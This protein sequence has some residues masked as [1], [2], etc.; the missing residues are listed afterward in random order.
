MTFD[1]CKPSVRAC[2]RWVLIVGGRY[3]APSSA[4]DALLDAEANLEYRM[5]SKDGQHPLRAQRNGPVLT[6]MIAQNSLTPI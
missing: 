1:S 2:G 3:D 6:F 4:E 5:Q